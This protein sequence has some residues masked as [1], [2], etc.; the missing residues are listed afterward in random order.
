MVVAAVAVAVTVAPVV[1]HPV[2]RSSM[3]ARTPITS[4]RAPAAAIL[5]YP[6]QLGPA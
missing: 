1:D 3:L 4:H 5:F 2:S 6:T